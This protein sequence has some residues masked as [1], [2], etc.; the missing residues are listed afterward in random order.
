VAS[1]PSRFTHV[2]QVLPSLHVA[3]ASGAHTLHAR[4]ALR[5]AGFHSEVFVDMVDAPLADEARSFA[6]LDGF[7]VPDATAIVYQLAV[8]SRL[9]DQLIARKEPLIVNYHNL[10]PASFFWKWAPDWLDAVALGRSQLHAL[11]ERATHAIAVSKFNERDLRGAGYLST[12]VV[13]PFVDVASFTPALAEHP[14]NPENHEPHGRNDERPTTLLFVG[15]LLPHKAA[16]DLVSALAAYRKAYDPR[17]RLV[18]VG[19]HPVASYAAAVR[20]YADALGLGGAIVLTGATSNEELASAYATA[21][22]FV[23]LSE[24][25]GFC[26]PLLEA[27]SHGLPV[28]AYAAGAVPDTLG[29][30][31]II[32]ADKSGPAIAAAVHRVVTDG[33]LRAKLVSAG[34]ERLRTFDLDRTK[35]RFTE[36]IRVALRHAEA[37][38]PSRAAVATLAPTF[39]SGPE[40]RFEAPPVAISAEGAR[41]ARQLARTGPEQVKAVHQLV[42]MLVP[43]DATSDHAIQLRRLLHDMGLESEIFAAAIHDSLHEEGMLIGEL[44]DRTLPGTLFVYQM[45]SGS[46][47]VETARERKEPLAVNYHNLTP[48]QTYDRWEPQIAADQRWARR[49]VAGLAART[50]LAMCDSAY[51]AAELTSYGYAGTAVCPVLVDLDRLGEPRDQDSRS[52]SWLFVGRIAPH[53]SQHRLVQA[54]AAHERLYGPGARLELVGRPGSF[55]YAQ[56][57]RRTAMMLGLERA[58]RMV[59]EVDD[60]QLGDLYRN[61]GVLVSASVHEGFCVPILEAMH[62]GVP[63]VALAAAAVPE[64]L[65]GAGLLVNSADAG[66]LAAAVHSVEQDQDLRARLIRAGKKR[67][68]ELSLANSRAVMRRVLECWIEGRGRSAAVAS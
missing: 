31:G 30:G 29:Y 24:Y 11:A 22:V 67:A 48:A 50:S 32:L 13:P 68:A 12:S 20:E 17:A 65:D 57:V 33:A 62:H 7:V 43:G 16:H 53:K 21:S 8:G 39:P 10:T 63:V 36:E 2:H 26:F 46:P 23:C 34:H 51:N 19:G 37:T 40:R 3:D 64:T 47:M 55:R 15:K 41:L 35:A 52:S 66:T 4:D 59:G 45:S 18:L 54:L 27:M 44:P 60:A 42:P 56:A 1:N 49:Q 61:A 9:V 28:V 38:V 5:A 58:V 25:E 6:E 14:E